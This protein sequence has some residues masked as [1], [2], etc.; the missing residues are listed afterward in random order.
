MEKDSE[1]KMFKCH[2][3]KQSVMIECPS[4]AADQSVMMEYPSVGADQQRER[5]GG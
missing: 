2:Q 5:S 3:P 4:V 1:Q